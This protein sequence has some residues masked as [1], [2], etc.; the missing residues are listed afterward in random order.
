MS[1][2]RNVFA[3]N[4]INTL[5]EP[6]TS[7]DRKILS[8][9]SFRPPLLTLSQISPFPFSLL[10]HPH[11]SSLHPPPPFSLDVDGNIVYFTFIVLL[12]LPSLS[13]SAP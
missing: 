4:K 6:Q 1:S 5:W 13:P 2:N 11:S 7:S 8:P 3:I 12:R 9:I 10:F